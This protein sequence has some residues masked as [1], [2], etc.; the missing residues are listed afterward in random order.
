M[1]KIDYKKAYKDLYA[2]KTES[3]LID[4]PA[5]PFIMVNGK[6]NPNDEVGEYS[7]AVTLLYALSYTI[8]MSKMGVSVPEGYFD[9]VVP[10]L[11]G[12]WWMADGA[13]GVD[14]LNKDKFC[15]T[16]M[17]RQPEFLNEE[18]FKWAC[19]EV[20]RK[21]HLDTQKA[22]FE[23]YEEGL[24]VQCMHIGPFDEEPQ[25]VEKMERYITDNNLVNDISDVRKHHE[26]YLQD[27][28][29]IDKNK[30]KTVLRIPVRRK[31]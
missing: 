21:K 18:L 23:V 2:P 7:Q 19:S 16:S 3:M 31:G 14:Y 27:P 28:R 12:F 22:V 29:K 4:V 8:K 10:P 25:T 26:I 9:Y 1:E 11:E 15:F 20:E 13:E 17:I 6:G 5:I 24:C 30:M